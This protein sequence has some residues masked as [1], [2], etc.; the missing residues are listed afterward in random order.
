MENYLVHTPNL[1]RLRRLESYRAKT[2]RQAEL[3]KALIT[4][5]MPWGSVRPSEAK[6]PQPSLAKGH[7]A[8][9][10]GA[11]LCIELFLLLCCSVPCGCMQTCGNRLLVDPQDTRPES[12]VCV[13][14]CVSVNFK[15]KPPW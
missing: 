11:S 10:R 4:K 6:G 8:S 13:C 12:E 5:G 7:K 9:L 15:L 1:I 3:S 14:V 2:I